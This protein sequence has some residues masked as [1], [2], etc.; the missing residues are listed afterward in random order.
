MSS[1]EVFPRKETKMTD[2]QTIVLLVE[3]G[4]IAAVQL[5]TWVGIRRG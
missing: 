5:L 2:T 1:E 3:V 4:V